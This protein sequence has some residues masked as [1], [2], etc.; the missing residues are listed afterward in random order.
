MSAEANYRNFK[1]ERAKKRTSLR[2]LQLPGAGTPPIVFPP[3]AIH[4]RQ[5]D[6]AMAIYMNA[7]PFLA[8]ADDY[9]QIMMRRGICK[10]YPLPSHKALANE[11][12]DLYHDEVKLARHG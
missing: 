1:Q 4:P 8:V 12:L 3:A 6:I 2:P 10:F 9:S 7:R 11:W 5:H